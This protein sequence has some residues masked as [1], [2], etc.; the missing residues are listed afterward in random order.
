ML[1][2]K[3][4]LIDAKD[5]FKSSLSKHK[6]MFRAFLDGGTKDVRTMIA[7]RRKK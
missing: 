5:K 4:K 7:K 2:A 3:G 6:N 1:L